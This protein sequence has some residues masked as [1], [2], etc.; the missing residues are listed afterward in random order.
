VKWVPDAIQPPFATI[1][2][3]Q[4]REKITVKKKAG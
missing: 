1:R 2:N 3:A 4:Y